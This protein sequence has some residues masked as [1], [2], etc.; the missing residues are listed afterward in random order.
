LVLD[1]YDK[2]KGVQHEKGNFGSRA[3]FLRFWN[4]YQFLRSAGF[5]VGDKIDYQ[6]DIDAVG[7]KGWRMP[8]GH[9]KRT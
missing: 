5:F 7:A 9:K 1:A 2:E 8:L 3:L 4:L 6:C